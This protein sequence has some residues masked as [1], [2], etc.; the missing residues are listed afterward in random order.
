MLGQKVS[1]LQPEHFGQL[2]EV[3]WA[4]VAAASFPRVNVLPGDSECAADLGECEFACLT[5]GFDDWANHGR[6]VVSSFR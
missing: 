6:W 4:G 5:G 1:D 3:L 2:G